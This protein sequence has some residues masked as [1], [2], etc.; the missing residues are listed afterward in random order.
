MLLYDLGTTK[1]AE[2]QAVKPKVCN[3]KIDHALNNRPCV[4][5]ALMVLF[6]NLVAKLQLHAILALDAVYF[7]MFDIRDLANFL[8]FG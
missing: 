8:A 5:E 4:P 6:R 7:A 3:W 1:T 2:I